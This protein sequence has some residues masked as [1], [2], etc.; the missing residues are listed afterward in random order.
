MMIFTYCDTYWSL[1]WK[2][3]VRSTVLQSTINAIEY[4]VY[5]HRPQY[6][7]NYSK[8][9]FNKSF[10]LEINSNRISMATIFL[11]NSEVLKP[12]FFNLTKKLL[13][14]K[15]FRSKITKTFNGVLKYIPMC[16]SL[17]NSTYYYLGNSFN[18]LQTWT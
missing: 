6:T 4:K 9:V 18:V 1:W 2:I 15:I 8:Q 10:N 7:S 3:K 16:L 17:F 12:H 13:W 11:F 14:I 5:T